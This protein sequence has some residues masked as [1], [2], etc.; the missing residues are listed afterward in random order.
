MVLCNDNPKAL[1]TSRCG[2]G[3]GASL[4]DTFKKGGTYCKSSERFYL[5]PS[6]KKACLGDFIGKLDCVSGK[7]Y[8]SLPENT[9]VTING[10][11]NTEHT[12]I[13]LSPFDSDFRAG[14]NTSV[15]GDLLDKYYLDQTSISIGFSDGKHAVTRSGAEIVS[16]GVYA[17]ILCQLP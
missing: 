2:L 7:G 3:P 10:I 12:S 11:P 4:W 1:D 13:Y 17:M 15:C 9:V 16:L 8:C 6:T 14:T 5:K